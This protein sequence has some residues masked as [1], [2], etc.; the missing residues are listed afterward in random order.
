MANDGKAMA[1]GAN[2]DLDR[3]LKAALDA[4]A[5]AARM[6]DVGAVSAPRSNGGGRGRT[7]VVAF[8]KA[9]GEMTRVAL[10]ILAEPPAFAFAAT[11]AG[12]APAGLPSEVE[13]IEAGHPH[14]NEN[15]LRAGA[16]ALE[17]AQ[18]LGAGDRL[19]ALASGGGSA[20]LCAPAHG[21]SFD[22]KLAVAA[23]LHRKGCPIGAMNA[24]R[25]A[26]SRV[27]GGRLGAAANGAFVETL[28]ISDA[29]GAAPHVV[30]SGPTAPP[31]EAPR[32]LDVVERYG[33]TLSD[34]ALAACARPAPAAFPHRVEIIARAD[35]ALQAA[36]EALAADYEIVNLG[37]ALEGD[38]AEMGRAHAEKAINL[39]SRGRRAALLS[40][41]ETTVALPPAGAGRGGR[42]T[43]YLLALAI[44]LDG[45]AGVHALAVDTDGI[46]GSEDNAGARIAPDTLAR[47][48]AL[49]LDAAGALARADAYAVFAALGDLVVTGPTMTNVN[50][51]RIVLID[52]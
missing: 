43:T 9:A 2:D 51:L 41:G 23:A 20:T 1:D 45:A 39:K 40:G 46:D 13:L 18:T 37:G 7:G 4:V 5:P 30:A 47:A 3:A 21:V 48:L 26:L 33:L 50:D 44:A 16:R 32:A 24:V 34:A 6:P 19:L 29:P 35:D 38:A 36:T 52:P 28:I 10:E 42:N 12:H 15:S 49:G 31:V 17:L 22:E 25:S 8:G 11:R 27:K 14:P